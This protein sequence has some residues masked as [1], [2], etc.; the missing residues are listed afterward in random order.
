MKK[1]EII[2]NVGTLRFKL[3]TVYTDD[4]QLYWTLTLAF[5]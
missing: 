5:Q 4:P 1:H 2:A 3:N